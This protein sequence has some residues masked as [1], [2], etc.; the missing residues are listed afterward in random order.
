MKL[1]IQ[2]QMSENYG[3]HDWDG[4]GECPQYWKMKGGNTYVIPN[5]SAEQCNDLKLIDD[6]K[7]H[8]ESYDNGFEEYVL[9]HLSV[10]DSVLTSGYHE[11]WEQPILVILE[12]GTNIMYCQIITENGS[13]YGYMK[14]HIKHK[15]ETYRL[16][17]GNK[18]DQSI[19]YVTVNNEVLDWRG[20]VC[21]TLK[22]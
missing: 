14:E 20:D 13:E 8:I 10:D 16:V 4:I 1:I 5:L 7:S 17:L 6:V 19:T 22:I 15:R 3:S 2:T 9:E 12:E 11:E 21:H 18:V